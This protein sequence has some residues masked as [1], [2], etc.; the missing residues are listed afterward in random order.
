MRVYCD[1]HTGGRPTLPLFNNTRK[2]TD[3]VMEDRDEVLDTCPKDKTLDPDWFSALLSLPASLIVGAPT[4][5]ESPTGEG[6]DESAAVSLLKLFV[7][8]LPARRGRQLQPRLRTYTS[9]GEH[10]KSAVVA[11]EADAVYYTARTREPGKIFGAQQVCIQRRL[12]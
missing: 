11:E 9:L 3:T 2:A 10:D 4:A 7:P 6:R 12:L 5:A 1:Y 8:H